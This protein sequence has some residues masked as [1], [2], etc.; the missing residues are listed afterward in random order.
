MSPFLAAPLK[1]IFE[2]VRVQVE[3]CKRFE[4]NVTNHL[5]NFARQAFARR[6]LEALRLR[7]EKAGKGMGLIGRGSEHLMI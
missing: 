5:P 2:G 1:P 7:H 3:R 4:Q 6:R